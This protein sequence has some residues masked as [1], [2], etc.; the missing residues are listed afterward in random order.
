MRELIINE[1]TA[2]M[3]DVDINPNNLDRERSADEQRHTNDYT[4]EGVEIHETFD[5]NGPTFADCVVRVFSV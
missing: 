5:P 2:D 3:R 4:Y 1:R